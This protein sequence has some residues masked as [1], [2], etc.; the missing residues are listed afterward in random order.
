MSS[1]SSYDDLGWVEGWRGGDG[2]N[3]G[4][5]EMSE[6]RK[7][8]SKSVQSLIALDDLSKI[9]QWNTHIPRM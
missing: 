6:R 8:P 2:R 1:D 5:N 9:H 7:W 4:E 3:S